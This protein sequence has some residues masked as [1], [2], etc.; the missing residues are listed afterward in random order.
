MWFGG[1]TTIY[2]SGTTINWDNGVAPAINE[3]FGDT[4]GDSFT[5]T[6]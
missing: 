5:Y 1:E 2:K 4:T 6:S 3:S